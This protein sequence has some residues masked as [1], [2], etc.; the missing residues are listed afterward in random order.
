MGRI[1]WNTNINAQCCP[2]EIVDNDHAKQSILVQNDFDYPGVASL[3]GWSIR[4]VQVMQ[5]RYYGVSCDH[6]GTDGTIK[7][8]D[9]GL[10]ANTFI[11]AAGAWLRDNNGVTVDDPGYFG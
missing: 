3:F 9:C 1:T 8:P 5:A 4:E 10:V 2:G 7:C 6:S 11:E